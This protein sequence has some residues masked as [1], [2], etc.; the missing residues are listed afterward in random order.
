MTIWGYP[1]VLW[2]F[3]R[4][5]F[6]YTEYFTSIGFLDEFNDVIEKLLF[7]YC[8]FASFISA[9]CCLKM[10]FVEDECHCTKHDIHTLLYG[11]LLRVDFCDGSCL[12]NPV[13]DTHCKGW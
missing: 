2:R 13:A 8:P 1:V 10:L 4:S 12:F 6:T 5:C 11:V 7:C 9:R 3:R